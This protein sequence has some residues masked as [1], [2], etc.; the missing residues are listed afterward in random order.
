[1]VVLTATCNDAANEFA[2]GASTDTAAIFSL[3]GLN[4]SLVSLCFFLY[5]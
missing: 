2:I 5:K 1:V 3:S 4:D